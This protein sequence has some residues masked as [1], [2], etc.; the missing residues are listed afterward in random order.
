MVVWDMDQVPAVGETVMLVEIVGRAATKYRVQGVEWV[1]S[2]NAANVD[3]R[4]VTP[5]G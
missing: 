4:P 2:H 3:I 1:P 5:F